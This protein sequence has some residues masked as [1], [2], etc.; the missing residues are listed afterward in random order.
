MVEK[1]LQE[2]S[3]Y[4]KIRENNLKANPRAKFSDNIADIKTTAKH[5]IENSI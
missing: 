2:K 5:L 3:R 4:N 1:Y